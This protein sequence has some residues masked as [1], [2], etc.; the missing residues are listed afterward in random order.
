MKL[1]RIAE[2]LLPLAPEEG[3]KPQ[4]SYAALLS[5]KEW[6]RSKGIFDLG[7]DDDSIIRE[8]DGTGAYVNYDSLLGT[9]LVP[10]REDIC[11]KQFRFSF[12]LDEKGI[13][14]IDESGFVQ[15]QLASISA[16]KKWRFPSLE[17]FLYDFIEE[18]I[19]RDSRLLGSYD[20]RMNALEDGI[21]NGVSRE[22]AAE[23]NDIRGELLDLK[24]HY[25]QLLDLC[26][27]LE[28]NENGFFKTEELRYFRL[29]LERLTRLRE[30]VNSLREYSFQ[31]RDLYQS[32]SDERQNHAINRLTVLTSVF[33]PLSLITGWF[34]MNFANMPILYKKWGYPLICV[35]SLLVVVVCLAFFRKK[36]WL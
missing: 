10:S 36:K 29:L 33:M 24:E 28:E 16:R 5:W 30:R 32:R 19:V 3:T 35:L 14:F 8:P 25:D 18:I 17:R 12:A 6:D 13:V 26:Q 1:Y 23:I 15:Q 27:E 2:T 9:F 11:G 7:I 20:Q 34:G 31:I 22:P 4:S 21:L